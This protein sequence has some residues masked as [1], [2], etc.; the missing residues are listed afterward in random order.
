MMLN[1][2]NSPNGN[3]WRVANAFSVW[4]M[5][6]DQEYR[7]IQRFTEGRAKGDLVMKGFRRRVE[8]SSTVFFDVERVAE[9]GGVVVVGAGRPT[10]DSVS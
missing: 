3:F 1:A 9:E 10:L 6:I 8:R 2:K 4:R 5:N 7:V